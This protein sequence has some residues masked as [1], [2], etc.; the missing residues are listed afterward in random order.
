MLDDEKNHHRPCLYLGFMNRLLAQ[1]GLPH[2]DLS[3][4]TFARTSGL[5]TLKINADPKF[6]LPYGSY[7]R[8]LLAWICTEAVQ[9]KSPL[10]FLG[11]NKTEFIRKLALPDSTFHFKTLAEQTDRLLHSVFNVTIEENGEKIAK[12]LSVSDKIFNFWE[13]QTGKWESLFRL[14]DEFFEE[15]MDKPVPLDLAVLQALRK[16]PMA[17]DIYSWLAYRTFSVWRAGN[18]PVKIRWKDLQS[19]F[20]ASYGQLHLAESKQRS[21]I[22]YSEIQGLRDFKK[23]FLQALQKVVDFYPV[24][25]QTVSADHTFFTVRGRR[26][27]R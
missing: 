15:I 8:L 2:S 25:R 22:T 20:G 13:P 26:L 17:M 21:M 24:L 5:I 19:Q 9:G 18:R 6:G 11:N 10:L 12:T 1:V 16:S 4:N 14:S 23:R 27:I 3:V 7:P